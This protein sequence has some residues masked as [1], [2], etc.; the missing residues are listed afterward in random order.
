MVL[1]RGTPQFVQ[2][3]R[4]AT[5]LVTA[6]G[7]ATGTGTPAW[8]RIR[9]T[10]NVFAADVSADGENWTAIGVPGEIA[11]FGAAPYYAGLAVVSGDPFVLATAVFDNVTLS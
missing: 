5:G 10:G 3:L 8:L 7:T 6:S 4:V 11:S 9:R 2:R 1:D